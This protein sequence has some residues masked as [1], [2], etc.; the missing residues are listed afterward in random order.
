M[1]GCIY[2]SIRS[3]LRSRGVLYSRRTYVYCVE[4]TH[5]QSSDM[6]DT[7]IKRSMDDFLINPIVPMEDYSS[8][9]ESRTA[10]RNS[11]LLDSPNVLFTGRA[12]KHPLESRVA[13]IETYEDDA[14]YLRGYASDEE[15]ASPVENDDFTFDST[16]SDGDA[17]SVASIHDP[18]YH[19]QTCNNAQQLCNRAQAVQVLSVGKPK[20]VSMPKPVDV[21]VASSPSPTASDHEAEIRLSISRVS[22]TRANRYVHSS[23]SSSLRSSGDNSFYRS[24]PTPRSVPPSGPSVRRKPNLP[25][26]QTMPRSDSPQPSD[27]GR[28]PQTAWPIG[29][30]NFLDHDPFGPDYTTQM[31]NPPSTPKRKLS[32]LS[33]PFS[34][35]KSL[36]R[37]LRRGSISNGI[38]TEGGIDKRDIGYPVVS[39]VISDMHVSSRTS[40]RPVPKTDAADLHVPTRTSSKPLPRMVA[41]GASERAAAI[42]I[43]PCPDDYQD[44]FNVPVWPPRSDS[45][46]TIDFPTPTL[47]RRHGRRKSLSAFVSTQM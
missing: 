22:D 15:V 6:G 31:P 27:S 35:L 37:S 9:Q 29:R 17:D 1:P 34:S 47:A 19:A 5:L 44:D 40:S 46:T 4:T 21:P 11:M 14:A 41:R 26:I 33:P 24:P 2:I 42:E 43:P 25:R 16:S 32:R 39:P 3:A 12:E 23:I 18:Q 38:T 8:Y 10:N 30:P 7:S 36:S 45:V 20:V 28:T 13:H